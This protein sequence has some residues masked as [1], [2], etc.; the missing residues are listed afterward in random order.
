[1]SAILSMHTDGDLCRFWN[2]GDGGI[3]WLNALEA[4][5]GRRGYSPRATSPDDARQRVRRSGE[6]CVLVPKP[7]ASR[8][9]RGL[10]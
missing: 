1:M 9:E 5:L 3:S 7:W 2:E 8:K 10:A 6:R 4:E